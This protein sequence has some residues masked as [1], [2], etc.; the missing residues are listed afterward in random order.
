MIN[1]KNKLLLAGLWLLIIP[2]ANAQEK[3]IDKIAAVVGNNY[4]LQSDV[5]TQYQQMLAAQEPV[6]EKTR[7]KIME[8]LLYQ[9]LLLAQAQK[10]SLDVTEGQ[11]EQELERRMKYYLQQF[12]SEEKFVAFYGKSVEDYKLELKDDVRDLL[13]E[14]QMQGKV[15]GDLSVTPNEV[16]EYFKAIPED[17]IPFINAEIEVGQIVKKP[18]VSAAAKKEAKEKIEGIRQRILK[19]ETNITSMAALYSMDPGSAN[20]GGLYEHIQRGQFVPEWDAWAFKLKPMEVS[21]VFETVYGYF[22]IQLIARRGDEVDARSLLIAPAVDA[23]DMVTDRLGEYD[24]LMTNQPIWRERLQGVGVITQAEAIALGAT[25]PILRSTGLAW[26]L[27][28]DMPY[29]HYDE[30]EFDVIVGSYGDAF[31]RYAIRLNEIRESMRIVRQIL[32]RVPSGDYR[33]QDK[34][35]TPPPRARIDESMEALIHHFKIFTEGFKVPEG[36]VYVAIES[37]RGEIGCYIASD[38]SPTPYRMHV[39]AP[40]FVNVQALPHMMRGG[41][42]ADAVA[43]ISSIDPVLGEVDR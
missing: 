32:D 11:L 20:K 15:T 37:P 21:E 42:V 24:V 39:R 6:N 19:G 31:D 17:S 4:I 27:R 40:S 5:E 10:D 33:I 30:L 41:L 25:G 36:E 9:K 8:E 12:G 38:G 34:K 2:A 35:V 22:I 23:Q 14:Q 1:L 7:C 26:D 18:V 29:M 3:V 43:V 13:L 16:K 28:R